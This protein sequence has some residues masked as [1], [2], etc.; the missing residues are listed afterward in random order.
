MISTC[1]RRN[2][3]GNLL[4]FAACVPFVGAALPALASPLEGDSA[5]RDV[6]L[7]NHILAAKDVVDGYGHVSLRCP[8][9]PK[10]FLLARSMAP[11]LTT[12]SDIMTF[13]L[14][15][16]PVGGDPR[17]AYVER[18]I[19]SEIY[20]SRPD[21]QAVVHCHAP[22]LIPFGVADLPLRPLYHM[23]A[24]INAGVPLFE[25]RN[26]RAPSDKSMLIHNRELGE[27]LAH[28]LADKPASLMRGHG[29][30]VVASSLQ[31]VVGRSVYLQVNA[32]LQGKAMAMARNVN[33]LQPGEGAEDTSVTRYG[34]DWAVWKHQVESTCSG[35]HK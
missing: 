4:R 14:D 32:N 23:S 3:F 10:Q 9:K 11:E 16:N 19:H 7:A 18:F 8:G 29:A 31:E 25:I 6:V 26:F 21:V 2:L 27:A 12:E 30:V 5:V 22:E 33:Y 28:V 34:R 24:F 15:A 13:D 17:P 1:T 20:R 35:G